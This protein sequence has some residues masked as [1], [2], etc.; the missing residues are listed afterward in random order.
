MVYLERFAPDETEYN[1][2]YFLDEYRQ[3][4]G[5]TYLEDFDAIRQMGLRRV[6]TAEA[7]LGAP[8]SAL[9][10]GCAYGPFLA[11]AAEV[12]F[13]AF[14]A[15]VSREAVAYVAEELGFPAVA[16]SLLELDTAAAFGRASFDLVTMWYVIE[17]I[18]E[19]DRT[20]SLLSGWVRPGGVLALA[21]PHGRGVSGRRNR[22]EFFAASPPDHITIWDARSARTL[23]REYGF[24]VERIVITG[25]HPERYPGVR[26]GMVPRWAANLHSRLSGWG[27]TFEIYARRRR[28]A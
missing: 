26:R 4:Y 13:D 3:Q 6:R 24:E 14:G 27:D 18:A 22:D 2:R 11:A 5:R 7:L 28:D 21:T 16:A 15:D 17:H 20:L 19:L 1:E 10:L 9:D 12:G 23:L 25:H 8:G